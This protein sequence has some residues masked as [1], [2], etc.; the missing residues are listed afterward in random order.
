MEHWLLVFLIRAG[1][2]CNFSARYIIEKYRDNTIF[3][4]TCGLT[5]LLGCFDF[6]IDFV[7]K[8][9]TFVFSN[10]A[11]TILLASK[12]FLDTVKP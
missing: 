11:I 2:Y 9:Q 6:F 8:Y 3:T 12:E 5:V 4:K 10:I 1:R 7:C